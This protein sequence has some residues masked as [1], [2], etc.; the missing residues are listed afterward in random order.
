MRSVEILL[1][2]RPASPSGTFYQVVLLMSV[3]GRLPGVPG[4]TSMARLCWLVPSTLATS[5]PFGAE[6]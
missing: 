2:L 1:S 6:Q 3:S 4:C 5:G